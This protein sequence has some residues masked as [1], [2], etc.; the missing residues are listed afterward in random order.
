MKIAVLVPIYN[1]EKHLKSFLVKLQDNCDKQDIQEIVIIDD[2]STDKTSAILREISTERCVV[3]THKHNKGKGAALRTG[4]EYVKGAGFEAVICMDGDEQHDPSHLSQFVTD[5]KEHDIVL[6][7]RTLGKGVPFYRRFGNECARQIFKRIF[8]INREDLLC[9]YM[10]FRQQVFNDLTW[11]SDDYGVEVEL[12][13]IIG[14]K[15]LPIK[16]IQVATIYLDRFKGVSM[17]DAFR[18]FI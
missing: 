7:Y 15:G 1:E 3:I 2:G 12:S 6:G 10:G 9:G 16:E 18:I 14:K 11:K 13:T 5:L 17:A 4:L 8:G